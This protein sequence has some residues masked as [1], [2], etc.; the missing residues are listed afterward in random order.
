M[1]VLH[2]ADKP[3]LYSNLPERPR[4]SPMVGFWKGWSKPLA[5]AG[6]AVTALAGLFHY[7]RVGP[8]EVSKDEEH[9]ALEEAQ[10]IREEH[11]EP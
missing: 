3:K 8:N 10:R 1:Y 9:E 11:H 7:T 6:M 2:H 5:V 4:I